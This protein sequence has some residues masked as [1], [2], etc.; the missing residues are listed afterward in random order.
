MR[1]RL[2]VIAT[3]VVVIAGLFAIAHRS[4]P[5]AAGHQAGIICQDG[6]VLAG[7]ITYVNG[8]RYSIDGAPFVSF[9]PAFGPIPLSGNARHHLVVT[10]PDWPTFDDYAGPCVAPTTVPQTTIP[11]TTQR[12][13]TSS[14]A[15]TSTTIP[16][17]STSTIG[18]TTTS[19][20]ISTSTIPQTTT[21]SGSFSVPS[22]IAVPSSTTRQTTPPTTVRGASTTPSSPQLPQL[23]VTKFRK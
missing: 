19:R 4:E 21:P 9:N 14:S 2:I 16:Q 7:A 22:T 11:Q 12:S 3:M 1:A 8:G 5:R 10:A 20:H 18:E 13:T 6:Q 23:P 15:S 17:V